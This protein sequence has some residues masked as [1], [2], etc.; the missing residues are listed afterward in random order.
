MASLKRV[1]PV[2]PTHVVAGVATVP[3]VANTRVFGHVRQTLHLRLVTAPAGFRVL[4]AP[5]LVFPGLEAGEHLR[6]HTKAPY[7]RGA[8]RARDGEILASGPASNRVYPQGSAFS[9]RTVV[10]PGTP[11][12][13]GARGLRPIRA[14][15]RRRVGAVGVGCA[16]RRAGVARAAPGTCAIDGAPRRWFRVDSRRGR[17]EIRTGYGVG[18]LAPDAPGERFDGPL[19]LVCTHGRHDTCCAV[20]GR[21]VAA[22]LDLH[23]SRAR[24]GVQPRRRL[25]L[26]RRPRPAP[27]RLHAGWAARR[28]RQGR[29]RRLRGRAPRPALGSGR[30]IDPPVVQAAQHHARIALGPLG[31]DALRP[32]SVT[33]TAEGRAGRYR[34]PGREHRPAGTPH[35]RRPAVDV[36]VDRSRAGCAPSTSSR[37]A[38]HQS[39]HRDGP[40]ARGRPGDGPGIPPVRGS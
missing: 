19:Y 36:R 40:R 12:S 25:P 33:T 13:V 15:R 18:P 32:V 28:H 6:T 17:E 26:R 30:S 8:I 5:E 38:P 20:R 27:P 9:D 23:P 2:G 3:V 34:R 39:P 35:P 29:R 16:R 10:P 24:V 14:G 21:P 31:V 11:R 7:T 4:W 22:A 37:C 1:Y